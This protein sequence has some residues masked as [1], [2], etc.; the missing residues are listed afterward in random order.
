MQDVSFHS[1]VETRAAVERRSRV[2]SN[3]LVAVALSVIMLAGG[4]F[5]FVGLNWDDFTHLHPDERFLTDVAQGLGRS[6]NLSEPNP[7]LREQ[8]LRECLERYPETGGAAPMPAGFFDARCSTF[9]PH[10]ANSGHGMY[11]YGTLPLFMARGTA[12]LVVVASEWWAHNV[13][14]RIDPALADYDGSQWRTYDGVHLVWRHLS[15]LAEMTV[16]VIVFFIGL[17]LHDKWIGLLA[18]FLYMATVFSIQMAHFGTADAISNLFAGLAILFAVCIQRQGKLIDYLFFGMAFGAALASRINLLPLVGLVGLAAVVQVLPAFDR[19]ALPGER[20]RL[21]AKHLLGLTVAAIAAM[22]V[23]RVTN[24]YAFLGPTLTGLSLNPRWLQD[25]ATAQSLVSGAVDI[26]P[27]Y[28]WLGRPSY[29]FPLN[30]MVLWGMGLPFGLLSWFSFGWALWRIIRGRPGALAN[31]LLVAWVAAYFGYMGRNW[32]MTMRYFL[33]IY[34][35]LAVLSAWGLSELLQRAQSAR[36]RRLWTPLAYGLFIFVTGFTVLWAAM[37]TNI[38]RNLLT[39]VQAGVWAWDNLP[40][41][42]AMRLTA[43]NS[44]PLA[45]LTIESFDE[46]S[47]ARIELS[48]TQQV[49]TFTF[50]APATGVIPSIILGEYDAD[51]TDNLVLPLVRFSLVQLEADG[52]ERLLSVAGLTGPPLSGTEPLIIALLAPVTVQAG[53]RYQLRFEWVE[54]GPVSLGDIVLP[55]DRAGEFFYTNEVSLINIAIPN[56]FG[57]E[58]D[59][60]SRVTR[61]DASMPQSFNTFI[62]PADGMITTI[63]AP[64]LGDPF[65]TPTAETLRFALRR[66]ADGELLAESVISTNLTRETSIAGDTFN[67]VLDRPVSVVAGEEYSLDIALME[68]EAVITG[69]TIFT[70][71]GAWDDPVPTKVCTLPLG[72]NLSDR[73]PP[74]LFV[75]ARDCRGRD[76]WWG[77]VNGYQLNIVYEDEPSKRETLIRALDNSDYIGI[78]SNR[79]YDTLSRNRLRWPL[80]NRYYEALFG[81]ELGYELVATFQETFELGPLRVSDQHLPIYDSPAWLN[82]FEAE[83]AFHVYDHPVVFVFRRTASYDPQRVR[84]ILFEVPLTR[85]YDARVFRNCPEDPDLYFCDPTLVGVAPLST[86]QADRAPTG[87]RFTPEMR[88]VQYENGAWFERFDATSLLNTNQVVGLVVWWLAIVLIGLAAW[89]LLFG[90]FPALADR[91]YGF[92]KIAGMF[93]AGWGTWYL[94][95]IH[96]PVWS[97]AGILGALIIVFMLGAALIWRRRAEFVVYVRAYWGRLAL[98]ELLTLLAFL[99]FVVVRL[100]N[101]DLWHDAYGGEKPMDFAYFNGV[102]RSTA[103]P[104]IDP[105]HAGGFINYYYFGYVIVGVPT[106]LLGVVPSFAYNLIVPTLFALTGI[107]AFS[108]A[109]NVVHRLRESAAADGRAS[110]RRLGSPWVS[111]LAAFMLAVVLGNLDT[112]RV[113]LTGLAQM[114]GYQRPVGLHNF[115][116]REYEAE[117][118]TTPQAEAY[119][120]LLERAQANQFGD[121]LRYELNHSAQLVSSIAAGFGRMLAGEPLRVSPDRWFWG[122]SR[123]LAETPGVEGQAIT[124]MPIF[125]FIYADLHAHMI[126]MPLQFLVF[127]FVLNEVLLAGR[128]R[129]DQTGRVL[130]LA[131]GA[132]VVGMLRATNT[133]EWITYMIL[134]VAGLS[135]AWWLRWKPSASNPWGRFNRA[136]LVDYGLYVGV[137]IAISFAAVLPYTTWFTTTY[138]RVLPWEGGKTPLWAYFDIHGLF[139]FLV[140]SLLIWDTAR[141]FRSTRVSALRGRWNL[142]LIVVSGIAAA[143]SLSIVLAAVEYQVTLIA[144]PL[145]VWVA[146]LFLRSGQSRAMQ[147]LLALTGLALGLTL[148]VE[149]VVLDGDIGRQNTVFK[150]YLQAWLM[151][152]VVSGV[153]FACLLRS[154]ESWRPALRTAWFVPLVLLVA[155]ASLFPIMATRGKAEFRMEH[156]MPLTLDGMDFM[157]YATRYEGDPRLLAQNPDLAPFP[158]SEDHAM[159]RWLQDNVDGTPVIMEGLSEDTQYRWNSRISIYTGMPAVIGWNFH[160]RQQRTI[161]PMGRLVEIRNANVNAFYETHVIGTAWDILRFYD[162]DYVI[163]GRLERA[164]YNA[165][166]LE[167]FEIMAALEMLEPVFRAGESVIYRVNKDLQLA[168]RG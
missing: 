53:E 1:R 82:E 74:G 30:N 12:E 42:F 103:F 79:F 160:Q 9:N 94:S 133:W 140:I 137:F 145:L 2:S 135:F 62:A 102:L 147:F 22:F 167:K 27:N 72:V 52:Q 165:R 90:L 26:P 20:E 96:I 38:Y 80:S 67:I 33:P 118:G 66:S 86:A 4:Y 106:L 113:A 63:H 92:A 55:V 141:W 153:A 91:G 101:P 11:V 5:R 35:A 132:I 13:Q 76:P 151:F 144:L 139:L 122:P 78:S 110:K 15:A 100:T 58:G 65:D 57:S 61:F 59:L 131:F 155:T 109:F 127:A 81:E 54:N 116:I 126:S 117:F 47:T 89:P 148:G 24:P 107:G 108:V 34:P 143:L 44:D 130:A 68:G 112:P 88:A 146:I 23:F 156:N 8:Q 162:V 19:R 142:L 10:N 50:E 152:S 84:D 125:T 95:S 41:D 3:L 36:L 111:G 69:G 17:R 161:E 29:I 60:L 75:D 114:G 154:A 129:R 99:A 149:Y 87:L 158:L 56:R 25:L 134:S 16:I 6:L 93:L 150:F 164:H 136:A 124:E 28:Q 40:G 104:P 77:L 97:A 115:L 85:V 71:E 14:A 83:E 166:G 159:I 70:W 39:R 119:S 121:R 128:E 138:N 7:E 18:A 73:P 31:L 45:L 163:V 105:W 98:I 48:E 46:L 64:R 51:L 123:V 120:Q 157:L 21:L 49:A 168:E 37:F 43:H 32:V